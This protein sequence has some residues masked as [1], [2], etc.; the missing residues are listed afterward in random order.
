MS[1][2]LTLLLTTALM[3]CM[4]C[5]TFA[6]KPAAVEQF[7]E[8]DESSLGIGFLSGENRL[9]LGG[10]N[11]VDF[12]VSTPQAR[13]LYPKNIRWGTVSPDGR[14]LLAT[15][16]D[17]GTHAATSFQIDTTTGRT[18][19]KRNGSYFNFPVAIHPSGRYWISV[20]AARSPS[21]SETL[22]AFDRHWARTR[23]RIYSNTKRVFNLHFDAS[24]SQLKVNA[25]GA[26]DGATLSTRT[27]QAMAQPTTPGA[28][29]G[30]AARSEDGRY[31]ARIERSGWTLIDSQTGQVVKT[32]ALDSTST[33]P[34]AAFSQDGLWFAAKG[35]R[36]VGGTK[37]WGV[38]LTQLQQ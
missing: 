14:L 20:E 30:F 16:V 1:H 17:P 19:S 11:V 26:V 8:A 29:P 23:T 24:G 37:V 35:Y 15:A 22:A 4:P 21:A 33:E 27:W 25:G 9:Y 38:L 28:D 18:V 2:Q 10:C 32:I 36:T 3:M 7:F 34:Q 5:R 6:E 12:S 13:C 31:G